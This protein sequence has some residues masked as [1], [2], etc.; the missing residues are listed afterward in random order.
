MGKDYDIPPFPLLLL[1]VET[2]KIWDEI[3]SEIGRKR[4]ERRRRH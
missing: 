1:D 2:S 3:E 4:E